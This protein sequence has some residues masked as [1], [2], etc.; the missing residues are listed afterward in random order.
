MSNTLSSKTLRRLDVQ[1]FDSVD[2]AQ[3]ASVAPWLRM[4]F[5][6]CATLAGVGT[7]LASPVVLAGSIPFLVEIGERLPWY[8]C[9]SFLHGF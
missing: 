1:G 8:S 7:V 2:S 4:A 9:N 3:L 6:M 5:A